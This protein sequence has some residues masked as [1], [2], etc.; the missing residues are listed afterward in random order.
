ME[1]KSTV[2]DLLE[3]LG[4]KGYQNPQRLQILIEKFPKN[5]N[6]DGKVFLRELEIDRKN[7]FQCWYQEDWQDFLNLAHKLF[8]E[9]LE[10]ETSVELLLSE[11]VTK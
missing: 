10:L 11:L 5:Q 4:K 3:A 8:T 2:Y 9:N 6:A 1:E 7:V